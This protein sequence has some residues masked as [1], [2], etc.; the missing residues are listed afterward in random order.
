MADDW[1]LAPLVQGLNYPCDRLGLDDV[2]PD[3][4]GRAS[5]DRLRTFAEGQ[6]QGGGEY[7]TPREVALVMARFLDPQLGLAV[8]DPC[9]GPEGLLI[10]CHVRLLETY[11][12]LRN[13]RRKLSAHVAPHAVFGQEITLLTFA[14]SRM[15]TVIHNQETEIALGG[16]KHRPACT[17]VAAA[18]APGARKERAG[19]L[20]SRHP[21]EGPD[22]DQERDALFCA[23]NAAD[24]EKG[25]RDDARSAAN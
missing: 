21:V 17:S 25:R 20:T 8:H 6:G 16:T 15:H 11:G 12:A 3:L 22:T 4:L 1:R 7:S 19:M 18:L 13:G 24:L 2:A 5:A 10:T 14:T 9:G 23:V